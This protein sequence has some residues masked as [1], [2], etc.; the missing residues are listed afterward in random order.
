MNGK[1][2]PNSSFNNLI[3]G[4]FI[5]NKDSNLHGEESFITVL[6]EIN[7]S[8]GL[9]SNKIPKSILT[10]LRNRELKGAESPDE[11]A[12]VGEDYPEQEE[13]QDGEGRPANS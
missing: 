13:A 10:S 6:N 8:P 3:R 9:I 12:S 2:I 7:I 11:Y 4:L 1:R 5:R